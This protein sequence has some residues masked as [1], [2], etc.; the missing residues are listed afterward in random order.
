MPYEDHPHKI[1]RPTRAES[2]TQTISIRLTHDELASIDRR[3]AKKRQPRAVLI[4][5]AMALAGLFG[6]KLAREA[7]EAREAV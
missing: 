5:E 7:A 6:A 2:P 1:G 3:A 4:R